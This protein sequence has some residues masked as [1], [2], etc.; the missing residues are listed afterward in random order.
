[1][2]NCETMLR[3]TTR[4]LLHSQ[5]MAVSMK[6]G[7]TSVMVI[8]VWAGMTQAFKGRIDQKGR[9]RANSSSLCMS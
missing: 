3:F 5:E 8:Y 9:G 7:K 4:T 6:S 1:M 2:E